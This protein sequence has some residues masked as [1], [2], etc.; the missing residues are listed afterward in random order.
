MKRDTTHSCK[1]AEWWVRNYV[2]FNNTWKHKHLD[3][4]FGTSTSYRI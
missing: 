2:L 3:K 4:W 1:I